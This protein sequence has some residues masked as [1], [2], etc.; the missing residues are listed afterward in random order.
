MA[1][2][3]PS[4]IAKATL[5]EHPALPPSV[6]VGTFDPQ[7][8]Y[9]RTL[10]HRRHSA[11]DLASGSSRGTASLRHRASGARLL[12]WA[13]HSVRM[14]VRVFSAFLRWHPTSCL[15]HRTRI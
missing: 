10:E 12:D 5:A 2:S 14:Y 1:S 15:G 13:S 11:R 6:D 7:P 8:A 3:S 4:E 9:R